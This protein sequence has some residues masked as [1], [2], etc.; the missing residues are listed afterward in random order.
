MKTNSILKNRYV[1]GYGANRLWTQQ[2]VHHLTAP[3]TFMQVEVL[4]ETEFMIPD[5][6]RRLEKGID[7][8]KEFVVSRSHH[9]VIPR[10]LC[11]ARFLSLL[12]ATNWA[13]ISVEESEQLDTAKKL[14]KDHIQFDCDSLNENASVDDDERI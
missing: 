10:V 11:L 13:A 5:T 9:L 6:M 12:Q 4:S 3:Y 2:C 14:L 8:L 1:R 7:E